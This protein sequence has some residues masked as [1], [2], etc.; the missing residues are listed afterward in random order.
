MAP[1]CNRCKDDIVTTDFATCMDCKN[2]YHFQC[3]ITE[4]S[5]KKYNKLWKC[6]NCPGMNTRSKSMDPEF[7]NSKLNSIESTLL[8][9][10]TQMGTM[11]ELKTKIDAL[12]QSV[13]F[14]SSE[15]DDLKKNHTKQVEE[16]SNF[17]KNL[18]N[19]QEENKKKDEVITKLNEKIR[20]LEQYTRNRN[21]EIH[22][23]KQK[24][25]EN[26]VNIVKKVIEE[27]KVNI[28][29]QDIDIAHRIPV[30]RNKDAPIIVQFTN[31]TKRDEVIK[32]KRLIVVNNNI[33]GASI[34]ST[35][36]INEN[37]SPEFRHLLQ[38]TKTRAR[39]CNYKFTWFKN[40]KVLV[41]KSENSEVI[42]INS[43]EDINFKIRTNTG[44]SS[45]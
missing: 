15:Y 22:G 10:K 1:T 12:T 4:K 21:I 36:Y 8:Q 2:D 25:N 32:S 14:L 39:E 24:Q 3:S 44:A 45:S 9:I 13:T 5:Y 20:N 16:L 31:R 35:V 7:I 33:S 17:S 23:I 18:V 26:C 37:L 29:E 40:N 42:R 34:G 43:L 28:T 11:D 27:L 30:P 6:N 38:A 19:L 41:R